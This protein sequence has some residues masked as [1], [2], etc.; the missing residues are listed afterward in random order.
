VSCSSVRTDFTVR[1][2]AFVHRA[3]SFGMGALSGPGP[4]ARP[5]P[6]RGGAAIRMRLLRPTR[7]R[8]ILSSAPTGTLKPCPE[9]AT[10]APRDAKFASPPRVVAVT[11]AGRALTEFVPSSDAFCRLAGTTGSVPSRPEAAAPHP[12]LGLARLVSPAWPGSSHR[13]PS[14]GS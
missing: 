3:S 5:D 6:K 2:T 1:T 12:S 9:R 11:T 14:W 7:L 8:R 10:A 4:F 13:P